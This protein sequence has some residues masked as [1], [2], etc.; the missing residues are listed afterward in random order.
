MADPKLVDLQYTAA[1]KKEEKLERAI[2]PEGGDYPWGLCLSLEKRELD[3][4]GVK[5]LP[6]IG[7]EW[8]MLIVAK[9]T[10]VN[11]SQ[12]MMSDDSVRVG[13]Q[14]TMAQILLR[15]SAAEEAKEKETPA[16]E[17]RESKGLLGY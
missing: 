4:L 14:V 15:E 2:A 5:G 8:H 9:V 13:L 11:T 17:S 10:G 7:D 3:M 1:E 12:G 6:T 16:V